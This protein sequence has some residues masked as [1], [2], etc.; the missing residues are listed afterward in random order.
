MALE[1]ALQDGL[2]V[3][4][5]LHD[6]PAAVALSQAE[7]RTV[8]TPYLEPVLRSHLV[9]IHDFTSYLNTVWAARKAKLDPYDYSD[10][11]CIR[12]HQ[13]LDY[14][15]L[16]SS[17]RQTLSALD[18][19]VHLSLVA[20][21][22]TLMPEYGSNQARYDLLAS[23]M[24]RALRR[25]ASM[26]DGYDELLLWAAFVGYATVF[27]ASDHAWLVPLVNEMCGYLVTRTWGEMCGNLLRQYA[28]IEVSYE[29][30]GLKLW[31]TVSR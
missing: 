30:A 29:K 3:A 20:V 18:D 13:L 9:C 16:D 7:L 31:S 23:H 15:P 27:S 17:R 5:G 10:M 24:G 1:F 22:T 14:A 8:E 26:V 11:V 28:W 19:M 12:L 21:M 25:Y 6:V 2:P 4:F